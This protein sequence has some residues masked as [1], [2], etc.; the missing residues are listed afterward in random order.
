M[1][2]SLLIDTS[3]PEAGSSK[4]LISSDTFRPSQCG[5]EKSTPKETNCMG[6]SVIC[7]TNAHTPGAIQ[8]DIHDIQ[9]LPRVRAH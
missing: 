1:P 7:V 4:D 9:V 5:T 3:S 8:D 6:D 2:K